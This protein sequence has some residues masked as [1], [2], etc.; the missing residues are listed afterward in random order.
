MIAVRDRAINHD[1]ND[2]EVPGG[3]F[4]HDPGC[5]AWHVDGQGY[6]YSI[7]FEVSR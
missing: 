2:R 5:Y 7:A 1:G 4:V 3:T 6:H